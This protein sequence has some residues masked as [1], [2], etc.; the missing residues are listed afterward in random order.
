MSVSWIS[1]TIFCNFN[2]SV[3]VLWL[4]IFNAFYRQNN[5]PI[6]WEMN[7]QIRLD[8][9]KIITT[10]IF[11][12]HMLKIY[13]IK[14]EHREDLTK[15]LNDMIL[16]WTCDLWR[17]DTKDAHTHSHMSIKRVMLTTLWPRSPWWPVAPWCLC[18][19]RAEQYSSFYIWQHRLTTV[20]LITLPLSSVTSVAPC[21]LS[22]P[23]HQT[24]AHPPP[25]TVPDP[26][27]KWKP[28]PGQEISDSDLR[29]D[30]ICRKKLLF[31]LYQDSA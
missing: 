19:C 20:L 12:G 3:L 22:P 27:Q 31:F 15:N 30:E 10:A 9:V 11:F 26:W 23:T 21:D 2:M 16:S 14:T 29:H 6:Y 13:R 17:R 25:N 18:S 4:I 24:A 8:S 1:W 5:L 28:L 7:R